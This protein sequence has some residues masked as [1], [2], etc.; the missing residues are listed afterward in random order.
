MNAVDEIKKIGGGLS[1]SSNNEILGS[2]SLPIAGLMSDKDINYVS[3]NLEK[4]V[5]YSIRKV[6]C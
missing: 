4:Y 3:E 5:I 1:I 6:K 2:L